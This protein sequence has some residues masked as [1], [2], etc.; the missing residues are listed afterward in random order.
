MR[1]FEFLRFLL[2]P[3][4]AGCQGA[5][6]PNTALA[7]FYASEGPECTLK[8]P[9]QEAT[10]EVI[11]LVAEAI[12]DPRMPKRRY[13]IG[14][15]GDVGASEATEQL[16]AIL[17]NGAEADYFRA[18]ALIALQAIDQSR[19]GTLSRKHLS[20]LGLFGEVARSIASGQTMGERKSAW[21]R[22]WRQPCD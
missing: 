14:Y 10:P 9:L 18:D 21:V 12:R 22:F 5:V 15:L 8:L 2:I 1:T 4:V 20:E 13:A 6:D 7:Q 17:E 19:A 11:P 3:L 16:Q